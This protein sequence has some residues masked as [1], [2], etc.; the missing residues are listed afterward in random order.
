MEAYFL[1]RIESEVFKNFTEDD[2]VISYSLF[3]CRHSYNPY[4]MYKSGLVKQIESLSFKIEGIKFLVFHDDPELV[5]NYDNVFLCK[6][7]F[8]EFYDTDNTIPYQ[9]HKGMFGTL[10]RYL[11]MFLTS[12]K[13]KYLAIFDCDMENDYLLNQDFMMLTNFMKS[14]ANLHFLCIP[15]GEFSLRYYG[16]KLNEEIET[17]VRII[18]KDIIIKYDKFPI[19]ILYNFLHEYINSEDYQNQLDIIL[20]KVKKYETKVVKDYGKFIFGVDEFMLL[21]LSKYIEDNKIPFRYTMI[22]YESKL[23]IYHW[24][25]NIATPQDLIKIKDILGISI[26]DF[27]KDYKAKERNIMYDVILKSV[28]NPKKFFTPRIYAAMIRE[29]N[30]KKF[31]SYNNTYKY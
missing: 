15:S 30:H 20:T 23:P 13:Y 14:R 8:P 10:M 6:F 29:R 1:E 9:T 18:G 2:I 3:T 25:E 26:L 21:F 4:D 28:K 19:Y 12:I 7:S 24:A 5:L 16:M 22:A 27:I 17:W 11:P 31:I